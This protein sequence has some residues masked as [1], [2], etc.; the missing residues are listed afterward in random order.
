[1]YIFEIHGAPAVQR[2]TEF[3]C[4]C[5]VGHKCK[6]WGYDPS[7]KDKEMLQWHLRPTAPEKPLT[8]PVELTIVFFFPIPKAT[9]K[10]KRRQMLA[11]QILPDVRPDADNLAYLVTNALSQI[12]YDDDKRVCFQHIYKFYGEE[13]K[14]VI[15]VRSIMTHE[16]ERFYYPNTLND[17]PA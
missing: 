1:M 16:P 4:D 13:P 10:A 11:R 3:A 7:K 17:L 14:T 6:K 5:P 2:H 8:G 12:V 9:S 15:K